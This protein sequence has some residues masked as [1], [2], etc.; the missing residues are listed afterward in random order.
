MFSSR[1]YF[2]REQVD[3][4]EHTVEKIRGHFAKISMVSFEMGDK[5]CYLLAIPAFFSPSSGIYFWHS[6]QEDLFTDKFFM[7]SELLTQA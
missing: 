6:Q 3:I 7:E 4:I 2:G 1:Q 5:S